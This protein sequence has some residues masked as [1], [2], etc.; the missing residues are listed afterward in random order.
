MS[1]ESF[2]LR[3]QTAQVTEKASTKYAGN[4]SFQKGVFGC[5]QGRVAKMSS[6]ARQMSARPERP[7]SV[8]PWINHTM[9]RMKTHKKAPAHPPI[10][11][12]FSPSLLPVS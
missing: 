3:D 6:A 8:L 2:A 5:L 11:P 1:P 9:D 10:Q 4:I 12:A 7:S